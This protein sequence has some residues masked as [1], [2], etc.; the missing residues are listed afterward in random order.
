MLRGAFLLPPMTL[1]PSSIPTSLPSLI[2]RGVWRRLGD[3]VCDHDWVGSVSW[4]PY[5]PWGL[6]LVM[7][8]DTICFPLLFSVPAILLPLDFADFVDTERVFAE[9]APFVVVRFVVGS[10]IFLAVCDVLF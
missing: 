4:K 1:L 3:G 10:D 6:F 9:A 5:V 8:E 7:E 2:P